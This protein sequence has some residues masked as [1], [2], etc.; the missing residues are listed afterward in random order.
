MVR[1]C[2]LPFLD[3]FFDLEAGDGIGLGNVGAD[4]QQ[5]VGL[6]DVLE[7]HGPAMRTLNP[8]HRLHAVDLA[9][10][11]AAVEVVRADRRGA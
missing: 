10:A 1:S 4:E 9:V 5:Y 8:S 7:G 11:G 6:N 2:G 3:R